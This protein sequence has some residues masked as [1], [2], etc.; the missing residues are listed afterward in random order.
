MLPLAAGFLNAG[1]EIEETS[2][3]LPVMGRRTAAVCFLFD[4]Q[5][6]QVTSHKTICAS[7]ASV[8]QRAS[9]LRKW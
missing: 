8:A 9:A 2:A 4:T 1:D 6:G 3:I 7:C 5:P